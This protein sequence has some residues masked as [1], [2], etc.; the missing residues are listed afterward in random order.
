M[1]TADALLV[2][3]AEDEVDFSRLAQV[4]TFIVEKKLSRK[5]E[6]VDVFH[7]IKRDLCVR[8]L[9]SFVLLESITVIRDAFGC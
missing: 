3:F 8:R 6:E 9:T 5:F 7:I 2:T 4:M 1:E